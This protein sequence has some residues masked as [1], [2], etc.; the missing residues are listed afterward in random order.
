[1]KL[2]GEQI[3]SAPPQ[4]VWELFNDPARLSRLIPGCEKL[5]QLAP[6]EFGG[7]I[8]VGI[9]AVKGAY[10]GRLKLDEIRPPE[11]YKMNVDGKGKQGFMHG[12]GTL[13]LAPHDGNPD[14]TVVRY[15]GDVQ[16]GG[17][18]VQVGQRVI[19]SAAKLM[20]GQFFAAAEAELKAQ[21]AGTVARQGFLINLW[22]YLRSL[23]RSVFARRS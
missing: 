22:R 8:N 7:T 13:D 6:D 16:L 5:E 3:L 20:L 23:I 14:R 19:E 17:T 1:V 4:R 15:A 18:L 11:H 2:A 10:T 12:A 9:A 21:A